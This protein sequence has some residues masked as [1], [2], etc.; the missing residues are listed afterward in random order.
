MTIYLYANF[1]ISRKKLILLHSSIESKG[2]DRVKILFVFRSIKR[3]SFGFRAMESMESKKNRSTAIVAWRKESPAMAE[4]EEDTPR[5]NALS[6]PTKCT[7][8][9]NSSLPRLVYFGTVLLS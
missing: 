6:R 5:T 7:M 4:V 2:S 3:E 8:S 9:Q 1:I